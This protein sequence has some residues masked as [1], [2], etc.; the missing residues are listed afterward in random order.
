MF[1]IIKN[2]LN[3]NVILK[4]IKNKQFILLPQYELIDDN[5][6][7]MNY[8]Y[9]GNYK[10]NQ[11]KYNWIPFLKMDYIER[12]MYFEIKIRIENDKLIFEIQSNKI[13]NLYKLK[14]YIVIKNENEIHF[15]LNFFEIQ[16]EI[17][18]PKFIIK[19]IKEQVIKELNEDFIKII[20][21]I[22]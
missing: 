14:F 3:L 16:P 11:T 20:N 9:V 18:I 1:V 19:K 5:M 21:N 7:L 6:E 15:N 10:Y 17:Y 4:T 2:N 22:K 12:C 13:N 8:I